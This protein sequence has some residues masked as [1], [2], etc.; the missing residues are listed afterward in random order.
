MLPGLMQSSGAYCVNDESSVAFFLCKSGYDVWLGNNRGYFHPEH[1]S[2]KSSN[3]KFWAWNLRQ[4]GSLDIPAQVY[5]VRAQTHT[6]KVPRNINS[7]SLD[8]DCIDRTFS[9]HDVD[10][11]CIG[12]RSSSSFRRLVILF[13]CPCPRSLR[14]HTSPK[15]SILL[16]QNHVYETLPR[17][18][19]SQFLY[20]SHDDDSRYSSWEIIRMV[21]IQ[22]L[23]FLVFMDGFTM[24]TTFAESLFPI[25]SRVRQF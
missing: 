11:P 15:N 9:G 3:P 10:V 22:G 5:F 20:P 16:C 8:I 23:Q 4:M 6:Q 18:F 1:T 25:L 13:H 24:G 14:R 7:G 21:R 17:L 19:R 12:E 2:L